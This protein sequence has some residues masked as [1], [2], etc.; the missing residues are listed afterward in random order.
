MFLPAAN[1]RLIVML[2]KNQVG[3]DP[4]D[5]LTRVN[6]QLGQALGGHATV[7]IQIVASYVG[8]RLDSA[9]DRNGVRSAEKVEG[10]F[11]PQV[12]SRLE[13]DADITLGNGFEQELYVL[14]NAKYFVNEINVVNAA[15]YYAVDLYKDVS[16]F[17]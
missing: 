8:D 11:V 9:F 15:R 4:R 2:G 16:H 10:F 1:R 3:L 13:A 17:P 6:K 12:D 7:L 5:A 14:A